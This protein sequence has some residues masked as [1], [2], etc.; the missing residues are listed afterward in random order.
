MKTVFS[1]SELPHVFAR[2]SQEEGR[3][4]SRNFFFERNVIY[5]YGYHFPIA[6]ILDSGIVLFTNRGY[7]NTTAKHIAAVRSALNHKDKIYVNNPTASVT[8]NL[9]A[10][11]NDLKAQFD[12]IENT[13]KRPHTRDA[14]KADV[15]H[16]I[17]TATAY[18]VAMNTTLDKQ[19]K[20]LAKGVS[21]E[22]LIA[23]SLF[24]KAMD[25]GYDHTKFLVNLNKKLTAAQLK[26]EKERKIK[27][28]EK[29]DKWLAGE[30]NTYFLDGN[31]T[32]L[33]LRKRVI[34]DE[35][36]IVETTMG[37]TVSFKAAKVLYDMIKS[38]RDI[39]G[40]VIDNYTVIG[41]NGTLKIGCHEIPTEEVHRF[42]TQNNW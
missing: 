29:L 9:R 41:I 38:G 15:D 4:S 30:A 34:D 36:V 18:C 32:P 33:M 14:A 39:K 8:D 7:S 42:A 26:A 17:K 6:K 40:H 24:K 31:Y 21:A 37:A 16:I 35:N 23:A 3:T 2:Q 10:F 19:I 1:P 27:A 22:Q 20:L 25:A 11:S 12:I 5:S 13:R 28:Q